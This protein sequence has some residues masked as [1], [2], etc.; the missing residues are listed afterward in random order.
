MRNTLSGNESPL[1]SVSE[2]SPSDD[3]ALNPTLPPAEPDLR[4]TVGLKPT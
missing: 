2:S 4:G 1:T 3:P